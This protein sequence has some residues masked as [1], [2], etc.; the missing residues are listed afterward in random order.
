ML[1][2]MTDAGGVTEDHAKRTNQGDTNNV[3]AILQVRFVLGQRHCIG[4]CGAI[5]PPAAVNIK[6]LRSTG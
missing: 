5:Y 3:N 4:V 1:L 6:L 2:L